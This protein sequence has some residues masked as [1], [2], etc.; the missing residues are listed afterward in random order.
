MSHA[1]QRGFGGLEIAIVVL[2]LGVIIVLTL[3]G[4]NLIAPM[5]A[6]VTVQQINQYKSAVAHYQSEFGSLPGD[7]AAAPRRWKR[8]PALFTFNGAIVSMAGDGLINGLYDDASSASGEQYMAWSDLRAA[9]LV[10]GDPHLVGPSARPENIYGGTVG[11]AER[12]L[13][14]EHVL[15]LTDVPGADAGLIDKRLDD[16]VISTGSFRA[17]SQWDPVGAKNTFSQPDAA[18]YDT[19]KTY[20]ICFPAAL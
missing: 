1:R 3:K 19:G 5:R 9:T 12:N 2:L 8:D 17:T 18:P 4:T 11:F 6:F 13:G 20:L 15:C 10:D 14:L 7:D 16:A